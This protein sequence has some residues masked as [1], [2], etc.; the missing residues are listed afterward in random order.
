MPKHPR[1]KTNRNKISRLAI[2][3]R[4]S[5]IP[6]TLPTG[7]QEARIQIH[8]SKKNNRRT[9]NRIRKLTL[10]I[11]P[12]S[13]ITSAICMLLILVLIPNLN[14]KNIISP[15]S[16]SFFAA[17]SDENYISS[18]EKILQ[19]KKIAYKTVTKLQDNAYAIKLMDGSEVIISS[20]ENINKEMSSLQFILSRLTME[21]KEFTRLDLRFEKPVI[22]FK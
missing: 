4:F 13:I 8:K 17:S 20:Q 15:I 16:I 12:F 19:E 21:S 7:R 14:S 6:T 5:V 2:P 1:K 9:R 22:T 18:L 10:F 3:A 11:V